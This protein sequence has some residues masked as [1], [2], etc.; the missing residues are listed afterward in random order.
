MPMRVRLTHYSIVSEAARNPQQPQPKPKSCQNPIPP[1]PGYHR[2]SP[3]LGGAPVKLALQGPQ[4]NPARRSRPWAQHPPRP[5]ASAP[6]CI[7]G[8]GILK[9]VTH[10]LA[11]LGPDCD[12]KG[13][14]CDSPLS[15]DTACTFTRTPRP[16]GACP[17]L[18]PSAPS[19]PI[20]RAPHPQPPPIEHVRIHHRRAHVRMPQQLLHRPDIVPVLQQMGR[21]AVP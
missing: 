4:P 7:V 19:S 6:R 13:P 21:E 5:A 8:S 3:Q 12:T 16:R 1:N 17:Q 18:D 20:R 2:T 11:P 14:K 9:S 10:L 15:N